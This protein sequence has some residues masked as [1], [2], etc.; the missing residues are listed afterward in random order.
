MIL[1]KK[2]SDYRLFSIEIFDSAEKA[3]DYADRCNSK[4]KKDDMKV[5]LYNWHD[6]RKAAISISIREV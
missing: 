2:D 1:I 4:R 3:E 6:F 5:A